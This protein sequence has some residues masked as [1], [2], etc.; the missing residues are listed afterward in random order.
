[1]DA[2][3]LDSDSSSSLELIDLTV[4]YPECDSS[5]SDASVELLDLSALMPSRRTA[6]EDAT[7]VAQDSN[8]D[9]T[10]REQNHWVEYAHFIMIVTVN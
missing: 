4:M 2:L 3:D 10:T 7:L 5:A 9:N 6:F 1:M 8:H